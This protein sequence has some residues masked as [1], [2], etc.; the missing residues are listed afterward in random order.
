LAKF[1]GDRAAGR[2]PRIAARGEPT[3]RSVNTRLT[4]AVAMLVI[5]LVALTTTTVLAYLIYERTLSGLVTSR[6]E[7]IAK[8]LKGKLE[9]GIDLGLPLDQLENIDEFLHQEMTRDESLVA[10][11]IVNTAGRTLF[12]THP[13]RV[14]KTTPNVWVQS[15]L[16]GRLTPDQVYFGQSAIGLPLFTSFGKVVGVLAVSYSGTFYDNKRLSVGKEL[17]LVISVVLL[18][19]GAIGIAGV[20]VITRPLATSMEGLRTGLDALRYRLGLASPAE[21]APSPDLRHDTE[22]ERELLEA[23]ALIERTEELVSTRTA[24]VPPVEAGV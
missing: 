19:A 4:I 17:I 6:F 1:P 10:I 14:G 15:L 13:D 9:A 22:I 11:S 16:Q 8:E 5:L 2:A 12:D 21:T 23:I 18:A 7:F 20:L 3:V 24:R